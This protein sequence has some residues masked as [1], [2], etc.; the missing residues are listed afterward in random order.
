MK[1]LR[2][3]F[4]AFLSYKDRVEIDFEKFDG[5]LFLIE[6]NTGAGKTTIFDA[7]CFALYGK[8]TN[9]DRCEHLKSDFAPSSTVCYVDFSFLQNGKEYHIHR[10]P[11]QSC[12]SKS[13]RNGAYYEVE[14][15]PKVTFKTPDKDYGKNSSETNEA[16]L[17]VIKLDVNQFRQTM[18]IAQGK[19][20]DLVRAK[21]NDR[22]KLLRDILQTEKY[23]EFTQKLGEI[24]SQKSE[25]IKNINKEMNIT[26]KNFEAKN[27]NLRKMLD[28][29]SPSNYDFD[30]LSPLME[31]ELK[32]LEDDCNKLTTQR[33]SK[34]EEISKAT[35]ELSLAKTNN[36]NRDEYLRLKH[37]QDE[38][39]SKQSDFDDMQKIVDTSKEVDSILSLSKRSTKCKD[40]YD[41]T[42]D[43]IKKGKEQKQKLDEELSLAKKNYDLCPNLRKEIDAYNEQQHNLNS[44][45]DSI[46]DKENL[47]KEISDLEENIKKWTKNQNTIQVEIDSITKNINEKN[48]FISTNDGIEVTIANLSNEKKELKDA[49]ANLNKTKSIL[50]NYH[51]ISTQIKAQNEKLISLSQKWECASNEKIQAESEYRRDI[52]GILSSELKEGIKCPVC[53]SIHHP[54][55]AMKTAHSITVEQLDELAD[56]ESK[57]KSAFDEQKMTIENLNMQAHMKLDSILENL[58]IQDESLIEPTLQSLESENND[59]IDRIEKKIA[60]STMILNSKKK[61]KAEVEE[62]KSKKDTKSSELSSLQSEIDLSFGTLRTKKETLSELENQIQGKNRK[63][64]EVKI[65]EL[66]NQIADKEDFIK[67]YQSEYTSIDKELEGLK[68]KIQAN[69]AMIPNLEKEKED[70]END[71]KQS[72]LNSKCASI[73]PKTMENILQFSQTYDQDEISKMEIS[74]KKFSSEIDQVNGALEEDKKKGYDQLDEIDLEPLSRQIDSL[75]EEYNSLE[76]PLISKNATLNNNKSNY[77][78]YVKAYHDSEI[79]IKE[80]SLIR[81]LY[82]VASGQVTQKNKTTF[83]NY[84]QNLVFSQ[85]LESATKRLDIM[86]NGQYKMMRHDEI[87][88]VSEST[89]DIDIFDVNTGNKRPAN[90]LSGGETFM[91]ALS[92]AMGLSEISRNRNGAKELDCLFIDEGFGSLDKN[93]LDEVIRVL[94]DLSNE[95]N[96]MIGII[97]HIN[98]LGEQINKK[99]QVTKTGSGSKLEIVA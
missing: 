87:S 43:K 89:L 40:S 46:K 60:Q 94:K 23:N 57:A 93:S 82:T 26:L 36:V 77:D 9:D 65:E 25:E 88:K 49:Q 71:F 17:N 92:L 12:Q 10:E 99:I 29:E 75:N 83:E 19:F 21:A 48:N 85:I 22:I 95:N 91:A 68:G 4:E 54:E 28:E 51:A 35:N 67:K 38:L 81:K 52:A 76:K 41:S 20:T 74:I 80:Y 34:K 33:E 24:N 14:R 8:C 98:E 59:N 13:K 11:K 96:R 1:P 64:I 5:S 18:M 90:N 30:T 58:S 55:P 73:Y 70:A 42:L 32:E 45:L 66:R 6:G 72:L 3:E 56:E 27:D 79:R 16:I 63:E 2:L 97:S 7:M 61:F 62:L 44:T 31:E 84:Y 15:G 86:S 39:I 69:E 37:N 50:Q 53:G 47:E 78:K